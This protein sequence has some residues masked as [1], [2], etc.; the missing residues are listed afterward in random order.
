K[1]LKV[2]IRATIIRLRC[3]T[4]GDGMRTR[5]A[6]SHGVRIIRTIKKRA[7]CLIEQLREHALDRGEVRVVVEMF[8]LDVQNQGVFRLKKTQGPVT[9]VA[10]R[11]KILA[12]RI[13][14]RV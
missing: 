8:F 13:P 11:D 12:T 3:N 10:F 2:D 9:L 6:N 5:T 14:V 7:R 1:I 4:E